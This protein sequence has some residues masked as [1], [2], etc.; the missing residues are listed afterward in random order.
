MRVA[1]ALC[2]IDL[3]VFLV[4]TVLRCPSFSRLSRRNFSQLRLK[5]R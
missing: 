2:W 5:N 4:A 3:V 1:I